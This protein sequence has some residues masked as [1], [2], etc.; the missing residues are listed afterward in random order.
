MKKVLLIIA[1]ILMMG[2]AFSQDTYRWLPPTAK[3]K[4]QDIEKQVHQPPVPLYLNTG[5]TQATPVLPK[6]TVLPI[7]KIQL[8]DYIF[9]SPVDSAIIKKYHLTFPLNTSLKQP[10]CRLQEK[11]G[12]QISK[13]FRFDCFNFDARNK[14]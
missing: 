2:N 9:K 10:S 3:Q 7:K 12:K 11:Y 8:K 4:I 1:A 5:E 6:K 13:K 14:K